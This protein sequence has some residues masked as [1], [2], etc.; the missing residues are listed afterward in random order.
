MESLIPYVS[1]TRIFP[2]FT[3]AMRRVL[4]LRLERKHTSQETLLSARGAAD[5]EIHTWLMDYTIAIA[6]GCLSWQLQHT[7]QLWKLE[8][9]IFRRLIQSFCSE[10]VANIVRWFLILSRFHVLEIAMRT[11]VSL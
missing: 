5:L 1:M 10:S 4:R 2:G 11:A 9:H 7:F 6:T 3:S 8:V